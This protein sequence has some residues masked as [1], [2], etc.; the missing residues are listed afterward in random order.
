[1]AKKRKKRQKKI[2][3]VKELQ[4]K[5]TLQRFDEKKYYDRMHKPKEEMLS[6]CEKFKLIIVYTL[7]KRPEIFNFFWYLIFC[8]LG[9]SSPKLLF[10]FS[11]QLLIVVNISTTLKNIVKAI[12]S[13]YKEILSSIMFLVILVYIFSSIAFF[14]LEHEFIH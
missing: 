7:F 11:I 3:N 6:C 14:L 1:M 12:V 8:I 4:E 2:Y 13:R 9:L 5:W 10:T